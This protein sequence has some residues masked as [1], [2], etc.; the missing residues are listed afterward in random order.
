MEHNTQS[1]LI[2]QLRFLSGD[3]ST[4]LPELDA[5]R[6]LNFGLD[7]YSYIALTADGIWQ[8]DDNQATDTPRATA[9]L[10]AGL[11]SLKLN[12]NMLRVHYVEIVS[13]AGVVSRLTPFD[14]RFAEANRVTTTGAP[15]QYDLESNRLYF[16]K[17]A[18]Q[19]YTVYI[20][21]SR[22]FT[23]LDVGAPSVI[24]GIPTVHIEYPI[25]FALARLG[26]RT[27]A[28]N[29]V[30]ARNELVVL[31]KQIRDFYRSRD[32]DTESKFIGKMDIRS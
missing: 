6:L 27:S 28:N 24:V 14:K 4:S 26:L 21:Y 18:D 31:E 3:N 17:T 16:D 30:P 2:T 11:G 5:V 15:T 29:S 22:P 19:T 23:H 1:E 12:G 25:L 7:S 9:S 8:V 32:E 13:P 10:T 20:Y